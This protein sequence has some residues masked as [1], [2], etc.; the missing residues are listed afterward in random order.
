ME[1]HPFRVVVIGGGPVGIVAAHALHK[2]GIDF[3]VLEQRTDIFEDAGASLI[4]SPHNLRVFHQ[5]GLWEEHMAQIGAPLLHHSQ[6]FDAKKHRFKRSYALNL[7]QENHGVS[8]MAFHRAHLVKAI[9][10]GLPDSAKTRYLRGKRVQGIE[11]TSDGVEVTCTD[12][13]LFWGSLAIG[14]DGSHSKTRSIMRHIALQEEPALASTWDPEAP[15]TSNY[16]CLWAS[17]PR[18]SDSGDSYET[19]GQDRSIMYLTGREKGWIFL[20]EKLSQPSTKRQFYDKEAPASFGES[21]A[22]WPINERFTVGDVLKSPDTVAGMTNLEEGVAQNVSWNGRIVLVGDA[23]HKFT[24]NSGLG[25]NNGMQDVVSLCN[26]L[27]ALTVSSGIS[28]SRDSPGTKELQAALNQYQI[29]RDEPLR[30]DFL[31]SASATRLSTWET[32]TDYFLGKC[33]DEHV[34]CATQSD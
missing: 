11:T 32:R 4:V 9:Y 24:P 17:F 13:S 14:A 3:I 12:G 18:L 26:K 28:T 25:F 27:H 21:F 15:F 16:R 8:L 7:L 5:L 6:G 10:G 33:T 20:Y 29:E 22:S 2:A 23:W 31:R 30:G 1:A 19:Q 34:A